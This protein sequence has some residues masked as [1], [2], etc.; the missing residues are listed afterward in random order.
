MYLVPGGRWL[1]TFR[2]TGH[3]DSYDLNLKEPTPQPLCEPVTE[4]LNQRGVIPGVPFDTAMGE[5]PIVLATSI[6]PKP[7]LDLT[8]VTCFIESQR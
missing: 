1:L 4:D 2:D 7:V 3:V 6:A 5:P 8:L